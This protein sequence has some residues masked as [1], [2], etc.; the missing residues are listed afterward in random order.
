MPESNAKR[1][2]QKTGIHPSFAVYTA[3]FVLM[4]KPQNT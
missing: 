4:D 1:I 2:G 3:I